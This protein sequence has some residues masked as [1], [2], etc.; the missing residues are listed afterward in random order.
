MIT[1]NFIITFPI[2]ESVENYYLLFQVIF[3]FH[4]AINKHR[5]K[6]KEMRQKRGDWKAFLCSVVSRLMREG[7]KE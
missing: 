5:E 4:P 3:V 2:S 6:K 1:A 7:R